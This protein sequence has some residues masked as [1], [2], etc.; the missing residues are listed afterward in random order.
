MLIVQVREAHFLICI[1]R[2][3][4]DLAWLPVL[5]NALL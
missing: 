4:L 1:G 3:H 2:D 5:F